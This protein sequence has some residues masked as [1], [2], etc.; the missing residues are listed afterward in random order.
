MVW[1]APHIPHASVFTPALTSASIKV[2]R[3][4]IVDAKKS[5]DRESLFWAVSA[6]GNW[7]HGSM[8]SRAIVDIR[9]KQ[10]G[11]EQKSHDLA[12]ELSSSTMASPD[13]KIQDFASQVTDA[14]WNFFWDLMG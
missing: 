8:F 1:F 2:A 4:Y 9:A 3:P 14:W 11:W 6:V 13:A 12:D 10:D 7:A 5:V